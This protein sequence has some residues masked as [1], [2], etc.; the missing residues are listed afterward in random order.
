VRALTVRRLT[1]DLKISTRTRY[2][3]IINQDNLIRKVVDSTS[4]S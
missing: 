1:A 4:L 2:K 3:R